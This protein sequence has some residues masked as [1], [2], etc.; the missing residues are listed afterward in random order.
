[1][2]TDERPAGLRITDPDRIR[3]LAH[4]LRLELLEYLEDVGLAT[5]TDCAAHTG[6]SVAN[7]SF[8]LRTLAKAGFIE[9]A[10]QR[11][12]E[13]PWRPTATQRRLDVDGDDPSSIHAVRE[14]VGLSLLREAERFRQFLAT[15]DTRPAGWEDTVALN[16]A[17][18]WATADEM[19]ELVAAITTLTDRFA[20]RSEDPSLRP[21]GARPGRFVAMVNPDSFPGDEGDEQP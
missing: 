19:R 5:A 2:S 1:M 20:G 16:S 13:K 17:R 7:C 12:R 9:P 10:A 18:F 15:H 6:E 11:G 21:E 8:H 4:P 3:A 14:L